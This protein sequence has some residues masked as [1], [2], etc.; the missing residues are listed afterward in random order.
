MENNYKK[1]TPEQFSDLAK[2]LPEIRSQ[3]REL[4]ELIKS[5][6]A[7]V[8][9]IL[10]KYYSWAGIYELSFVEQMAYLFVLLGM[11]E[12]IHEIALSTMPQQALI[13]ASEDGGKLDQWYD[14]NKDNVEKK[15]LIWLVVV[16]QRNIFSIMLFHLSLGALVD[17]VR[18]GSSEAFFK[19]VSVDRSILSCPT[20]ADRLSL[21][22]L[23]NDKSF[24]IHLRKAL[25]G[26]SQ[27]HMAA[28]GDLRYAIVLLRDA[29]F[30]KFTDDELISFFVGNGLYPKHPSAA[31]NLRKHIQA[32]R[33][34]PTT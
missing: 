5:E 33:K 21:A 10:G 12:P 25:K 19:A 34:F 32:A 23:R 2:K 31:K 18:N 6:P 13:E 30:D 24:F 8:N 28:I 17:Q 1:L 9:E 22:E 27:K 7:R 29:G 16:L 3:K 11:H 26:P 4:A 15:H 14:L 20:F